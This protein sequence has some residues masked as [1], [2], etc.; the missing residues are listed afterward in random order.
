MP[1]NLV[2]LVSRNSDGSIRTRE[3]EGFD[4]LLTSHEQIGI[5]DCSTDLDLRACPVFRGLVGPIPDGK[6]IARY[7]TPEVFEVLTKEWANIRTKRRRRRSTALPEA[8]TPATAAPVIIG[9]HLAWGS[10]TVYNV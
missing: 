1:A 9:S 8:G 3:F 7:E 2:R 4:E 10:A 6:G 5:D